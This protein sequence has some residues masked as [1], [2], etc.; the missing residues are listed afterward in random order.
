MSVAIWVD[1]G[2]CLVEASGDIDDSRSSELREALFKAVRL[3]RGGTVLLVEDEITRV[4]ESARRVLQ[5]YVRTC[6]ES[7]GELAVVCTDGQVQKPGRIS[8]LGI[9]E[10]QYGDLDDAVIELSGIGPR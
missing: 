2:V 8:E 5:F 10:R 4:C 7:G 3:S 9:I 1:R 6:R